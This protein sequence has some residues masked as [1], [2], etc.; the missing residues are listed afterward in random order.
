MANYSFNIVLQAWKAPPGAGPRL[1][2]REEI[3]A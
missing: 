1:S 3:S 2:A